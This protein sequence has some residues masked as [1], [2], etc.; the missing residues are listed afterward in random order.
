M[1]NQADEGNIIE[2]TD[3]EKIQ[4]PGELIK[5]LQRCPKKESLLDVL[6]LC[7]VPTGNVDSAC[8]TRTPHP[9]ESTE[10]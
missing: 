3:A 5:K 2:G 7:P 8:Q 9:L 10:S 4:G 1:G 6:L